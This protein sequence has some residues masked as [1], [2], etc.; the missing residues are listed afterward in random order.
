[1]KSVALPISEIT[2]I[3]F[4]SLLCSIGRLEVGWG[5]VACCNGPLQHAT[6]PHPTS[7]LPPNFPMF[8]VNRWIDFGLRRG[9]VYCWVRLIVSAISYFQPIG[10]C[11]P[12]PD[13]PT[14]RGQ[15]QYRALHYRASR[16]KKYGLLFPQD[17]VFASF[18]E[19]A[20]P[21]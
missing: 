6:F 13:L 18:V 5:K 1:L 2:A 17:G 14:F 4:L 19:I 9:K 12:V 10:L 8:P 20:T 11:G 7:S 16:S 3:G 15:T 21:T